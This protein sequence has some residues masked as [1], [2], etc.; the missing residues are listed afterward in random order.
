MSSSGPPGPP[1]AGWYVDPLDAGFWR[2]WDGTAWTTELRPQQEA[3]PPARWEPIDPR[4]VSYSDSVGSG[5][6]PNTPWV[7]ILAASPYLTLA[8]AGV[9]Q[10]AGL[11]LFQQQLGPIGAALVLVPLAIIPAWIL[12]G[13]DARALRRRGLPR[14]SILWMLLLPPLAYFLARR[15]RLRTVGLRSTG[16]QILFGVLF[17]IYGVMT[18]A[19][20]VLVLVLFGSIIGLGG[21]PFQPG[22]YGIGIVVEQQ[23]RAGVLDG[24]GEPDPGEVGDLLAAD[25]GITTASGVID[26]YPSESIIARGSTFP[27]SVLRFDDPLTA[28]RLDVT[29]TGTGAVSYTETAAN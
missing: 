4:F 11:A 27:C 10:A 5:E 7:W 29:I 8:V 24:Q 17:G 15:T 12:A 19:A 26:C 13:L 6:R 9:L 20:V 16:P 1:P 18:I 23:H 25:L 21:S 2:W 22:A 14:A 28:T 3:P